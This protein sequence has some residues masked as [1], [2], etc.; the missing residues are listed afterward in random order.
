VNYRVFHP[1]TVLFRSPQVPYHIPRSALVPRSRT[2]TPQFPANPLADDNTTKAFSTSTHHQ[3]DTSSPTL[4]ITHLPPPLTNHISLNLQAG[5]N[6]TSNRQAQFFWAP[7]SPLRN[8]FLILHSTPVSSFT[9]AT[10]S[11]HPQQLS[12]SLEHSCY[13]NNSEFQL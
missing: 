9:R 11:A 8:S 13:A 1:A 7:Q 5:C 4:E 3:H 12:H 6:S 2:F 10:P